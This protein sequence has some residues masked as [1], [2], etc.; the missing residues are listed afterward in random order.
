MDEI[1]DVHFETPNKPSTLGYI[2]VR[3]KNLFEGM[4][5]IYWESYLLG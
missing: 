5:E 1:V 2:K 4:E 3:T